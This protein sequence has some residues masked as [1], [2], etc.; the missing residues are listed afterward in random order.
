[1]ED[2]EAYIKRAITDIARKCHVIDITVI[3]T[4]KKLYNEN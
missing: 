2:V 4:F 1:M 3:K